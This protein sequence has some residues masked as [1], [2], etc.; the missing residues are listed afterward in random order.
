LDG[1]DIAPQIR[2]NLFP[3]IKT[4]SR[5]AGGHG[6]RR[7]FRDIQSYFTT[8]SGKSQCRALPLESQF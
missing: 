6:L 5:I 2:S 8:F 3:R 1:A 4:V 7:S